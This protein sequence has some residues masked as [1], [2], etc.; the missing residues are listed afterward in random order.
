MLLRLLG[1]LQTPDAGDV[2]VEGRSTRELGEEARAELRARRFGFVFAA[3]FLLTSFNVIENVA[4][5]LFKISHVTPEEARR[6]TE[7]MLSFVGLAEAA[8]LPVAELSPRAQ[9]QAAVAR[10]L[11]NEPSFLFVENLGSE[12]NDEDLAAF[13]DLLQRVSESSTVIATASP[14]RPLR[15]R[16]HVLDVADGA[17]VA[18]TELSPESSS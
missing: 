18:E 2:I 4:M 3:P 13:V 7:A 8:E 15:G 11:I 12:L 14:E 17:I 5:P 16:I 1:L 10:G 6:R 9:F